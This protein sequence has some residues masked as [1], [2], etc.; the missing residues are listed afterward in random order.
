MWY[1]FAQSPVEDFVTSGGRTMLSF[2]ED[3]D[4]LI[5]HLRANIDRMYQDRVRRASWMDVP[6]THTWRPPTDVF[7]S[8]EAV[9][10]RI[11]VAGMHQ[12]DFH[13]STSERLLIISGYRRDP[14]P[15]VVYHQMEVRY[16]EFRV[17]VFLHWSIDQTRVQAIYENG[18]LTL[19]LP[20]AQRRQI[21]VVDV[22]G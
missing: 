20:R 12:S 22:D 1:N 15:K 8:A 6:H 9:I 21:P 2:S 4:D 17:E 13:I 18:F 5:D 14:S 10:V 7:E 16:G 19:T 3:H 11:E